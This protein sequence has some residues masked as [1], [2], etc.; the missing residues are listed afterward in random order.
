MAASRV[1]TRLPPAGKLNSSSDSDEPCRSQ[2]RRAKPSARRSLPPNRTPP[3]RCLRLAEVPGA[4]RRLSAS[5]ATPAPARRCWQSISP[6]TP[7]ARSLFAAFTGKA[8][9]VMRNRGCA[10]ARTLHSLIYRPRGEKPEKETGELQPAFAHQPREPRLEGAAHRR[11]RMLDGRRKARP[12]SPVL[13]HA[14]CWC[15]AIPASC[16]R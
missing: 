14:R 10:N 7:T 6:T 1:G 13:R 4:S 11:R 16:R 15:S 5:S 12:R 9:Q 3:P 8:A 2:I